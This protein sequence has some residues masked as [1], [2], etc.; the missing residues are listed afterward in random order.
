V[1]RQACPRKIGKKVRGV[2]NTWILKY[3][4]SNFFGIS[5]LGIAGTHSQLCIL[6]YKYRNAAVKDDYFNWFSH[7]ACTHTYL[8]NFRLKKALARTGK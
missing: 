8:A 5:A 6:D 4:A 3:H 1:S 2:Q 7:Q